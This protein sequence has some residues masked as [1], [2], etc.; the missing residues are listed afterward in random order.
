M[1]LDKQTGERMAAP[2]LRLF[3]EVIDGA[4]ADFDQNFAQGRHLLSAGVIAGIRHN[5][6]ARKVLSV[7]ESVPGV[8]PKIYRQ[9]VMLTAK[10]FSVRFN[11]M[12]KNLR[13]RRN[14]TAQSQ[15]LSNQQPLMF[16]D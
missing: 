4:E 2:Y 12:D 11:K 10:D 9:R 6:M 1:T 16:D 5:L 15:A 8:H 13:V 3:C 7:F 14:K